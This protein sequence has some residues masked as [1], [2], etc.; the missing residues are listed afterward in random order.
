MQRSGKNGIAYTLEQVELIW[1]GIV[2]LHIRLTLKIRR[3]NK[4]INNPYLGDMCLSI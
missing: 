2:F 3:I 1:H 4:Y